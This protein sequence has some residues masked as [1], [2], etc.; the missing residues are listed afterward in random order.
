MRLSDSFAAVLVCSA[1]H[2]GHF[3]VRAVGAF[4]EFEFILH[5]EVFL[6]NQFALDLSQL[7]FWQ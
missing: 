2:E 4:A 1:P 7:T 3:A 5:L 6:F